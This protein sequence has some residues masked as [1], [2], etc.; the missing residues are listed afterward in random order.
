MNLVPTTKYLDL[1]LD[2]LGLIS[3]YLGWVLIFTS[4][5]YPLHLYIFKYE[6]F[7]SWYID[8]VEGYQ[9]FFLGLIIGSIYYWFSK[10]LVLRK[11]IRVI[12]A[13][14]LL[15]ILPILMIYS[16]LQTEYSKSVDQYFSLYHIVLFS[17][18][19][20][21]TGLLTTIAGLKFSSPVK[22]NES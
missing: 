5:F 16:F 13:G 4:F 12:I 3:N 17:I 20:L 10:G 15:V 14:L 22:S 2:L 11:K 6:K 7:S 18:F 1:T 8:G 21:P 9:M 19:S